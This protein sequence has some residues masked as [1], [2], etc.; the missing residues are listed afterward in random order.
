MI[1]S[2]ASTQDTVFQPVGFAMDTMTVE[3]F[4]T[5]PIAVNDFSFH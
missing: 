3:T 2:N 5:K 1:N 4:P